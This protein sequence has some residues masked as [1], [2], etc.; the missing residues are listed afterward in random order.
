MMIDFRNLLAPIPIPI[1]ANYNAL[2]T[3]SQQTLNC[4]ELVC[5]A[6]QKKDKTWVKTWVQKSDVLLE[7]D[8]VKYHVK[9]SG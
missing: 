3:Y 2:S 9:N 6:G 4:L 1:F 8:Q 5:D 7:L